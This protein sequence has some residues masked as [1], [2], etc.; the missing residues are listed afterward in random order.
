M[1]D[2]CLLLGDEAEGGKGAISKP[3][4][5][6][7]RHDHGS[8][9]PICLTL[10]SPLPCGLQVESGGLLRPKQCAGNDKARLS[11]LNCEKRGCFHLEPSWDTAVTGIGLS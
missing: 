9:L 11:G 2:E 3:L 8:P 7:L 5:D 10:T 6:C 1:F 4:G